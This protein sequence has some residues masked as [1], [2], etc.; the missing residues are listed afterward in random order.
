[1][2]KVLLIVAAGKSSRF[3]GY[4]KA[5]CILG[6]KMNVENTIE[7][8]SECFDE[9][10]VGLNEETV[11]NYPNLKLN[12]HVL[13]I[14]TGQGEAM[15]ILKLIRLVKKENEDLDKIY[16]CWGDAF[17]VDELPFEQFMSQIKSDDFNVACSIDEKPYAWFDVDGNDYIISSH[18]KKEDGE[19]EKGIH[20]QS[21]FCFNIE[22]FIKYITDY[23]LSIGINN[24][25]YDPNEKKEV[26]TLDLFTYLYK[27]GVGVKTILIDKNKVL[28]FNTKE[29][30]DK[31]VEDYC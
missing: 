9:I 31:I 25:D 2:K 22:N 29:E 17:F 27:N 18:F 24:E 6:N 15:S 10:Y 7:K 26:K 23:R 16:I 30:L 12:A 19:I 3:G 8:A 28:S 1:M 21:L 20:D 4:P 14:T 13:S 11:A 5:F